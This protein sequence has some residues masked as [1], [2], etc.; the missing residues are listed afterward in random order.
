MFKFLC[1]IGAGADCR[2]VLLLVTINFMLFMGCI[3]EFGLFSGGSGKE[4]RTA[5]GSGILTEEAEAE[6]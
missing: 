3:S 4:L 2:F 6:A 1:S 5:P